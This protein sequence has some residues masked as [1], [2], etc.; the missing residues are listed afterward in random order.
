MYLIEFKICVEKC[1][2]NPVVA[3]HKIFLKFCLKDT[4]K[5][6][7][8]KL[9]E[10]IIYVADSYIKFTNSKKFHEFITLNSTF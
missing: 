1:N 4:K 10:N 6:L 9:I 2:G 7:R 5:K 3:T 8:K